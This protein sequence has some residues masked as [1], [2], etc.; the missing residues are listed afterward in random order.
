MADLATLGLFSLLRDLL[1]PAQT[2]VLADVPTAVTLVLAWTAVA[3]PA[4]A[5]IAVW[6]FA[7]A[8][9]HWVWQRLRGERGPVIVSLFDVSPA[10]RRALAVGSAAGALIG[11][12][13]ALLLH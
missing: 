9:G 3:F 11:L 12:A 8:L 2:W 13:L 7:F 5:G 4:L 6:V 1:L 10:Y